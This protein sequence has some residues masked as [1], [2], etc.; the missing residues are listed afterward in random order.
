MTYFSHGLGKIFP[1]NYHCKGHNRSNISYLFQG[2]GDVFRF[3]SYLLEM[4]DHNFHTFTIKA[5]KAIYHFIH[6][7]KKDKDNNWILWSSFWKLF[8]Q[9]F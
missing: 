1:L 6:C 7:I 8:P 3:V 4:K 5:I 2:V 9:N